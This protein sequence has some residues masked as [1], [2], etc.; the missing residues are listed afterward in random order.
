MI[1]FGCIISCSLIGPNSFPTKLQ[2]TSPKMYCEAMVVNAVERNARSHDATS[3]RENWPVAG[4]GLLLLLL[5]L[6]SHCH[7]NCRHAE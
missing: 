6:V 7:M 5:L 2:H 3:S 4:F 1:R